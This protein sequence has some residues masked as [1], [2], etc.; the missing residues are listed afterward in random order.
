MH[1]ACF[2][3]SEMASVA[4]TCRKAGGWGLETGQHAAPLAAGR[5]GVPARNPDLSD[6]EDDA[7]QIIETHSCQPGWT[8]PGRQVRT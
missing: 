4:C 5:L 7:G 2:T 1:R 6:G 3:P 8:T